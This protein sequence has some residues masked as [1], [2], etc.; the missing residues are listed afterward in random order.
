MNLKFCLLTS[1]FNS[2]QYID[3]CIKSVINQIYKNWI[4][5]VSDDGSSDN[6]KEI[7]LKYCKE[8][9][10]ILY[11][12]QAYKSEI[13]KDINKFVPVDCDYFMMMDSDDRLLPNCLEVYNQILLDHKDDNIVFASCEAS[14]VF[15][16]ERKY[17]SLLYLDTYADLDNNKKLHDGCNVWGNLRAIKNL[18]N[19]RFMALDL[20]DQEKYYCYLEDHMFYVQMQKYGNYLNIKRNLY[21]FIRRDGSTSSS[22]DIYSN[23]KNLALELSK[24]FINQ[25]HLIGKSVKTWEKNLFDDANSFLMSA[26]N[27]DSKSKKINFFTNSKN[28]FTDLYKLYYDKYLTINNIDHYFEYCIINT[29]FYDLSEIKELFKIIRSKK[30]LE[31]VIYINH[32][33]KKIQNQD[34]I[35]AIYSD[36]SLCYYWSAHGPYTYYIINKDNIY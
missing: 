33:H 2:E 24:D 13:V 12:N 15:N 23:R 11:F 29:C 6:T 1:F 4:W 3:S 28:D 8:N 20:P 17:P 35:D 31:V 27:F 30:P 5:F 32:N 34:L 14:W 9:N 26:F 10:N 7:L 21:D 19:F 25:N 22:T 18:P 36:L 16:E